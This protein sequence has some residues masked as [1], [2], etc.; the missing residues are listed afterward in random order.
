MCILKKFQTE[1]IKENFITP[2]DSLL[3]CV[4][5]GQD[6]ISLLFLIKKLQ[7]VWQWRIGIVYCDHLIRLRS[8]Q[9]G[10]FLEKISLNLNYDYYEILSTYSMK[11]E[12]EARQWRYKKILKLA[13]FHK[14]SKILTGHTKQD[15]TETFFLNLLRGS[16]LTGFNSLYKK[17]NLIK[18]INLIRPTLNFSRTEFWLFTQSFSLPIHQDQT[19]KNLRFLRNRVRNELFPY[20]KKEFNKNLEYQISK[21]QDSVELQNRLI[22]KSLSNFDIKIK[23]EKILIPFYKKTPIFIQRNLILKVIKF[24]KLGEPNFKKIEKLR[25]FFFFE[26]KKEKSYLKFEK[27]QIQI[28]KKFSY[29]EVT[30]ELLKEE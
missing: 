18:N 4:S 30:K 25:I 17:V 24:L 20:L 2:Y 6:S 21:T 13:Y 16:N 3:I 12:S 14:Y 22:K 1:L 8:T 19:N 27:F 28:Q 15:K 5:G 11:S 26:K 7:K 9:N 10:S 29:I 23:K